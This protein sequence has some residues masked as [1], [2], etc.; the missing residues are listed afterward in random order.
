MET[1]ITTPAEAPRKP[2]FRWFRFLVIPTL[3][4]VSSL[5]LFPMF[6]TDALTFPL[7]VTCGV[8]ILWSG[9]MLFGFRNWP[10][11]VI[12]YIA[13]AMA[14]VWAAAILHL[15]TSYGWH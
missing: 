6:L 14:V 15:L 9:Y 13:T 8:P 5:V 1:A 7:L 11:R 10:E 2:S 3:I 12:G 4:N